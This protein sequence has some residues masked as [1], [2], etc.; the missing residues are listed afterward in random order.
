MDCAME[1]SLNK[2]VVHMYGVYITPVALASHPRWS[3]GLARCSPNGTRV[4]LRLHT[5]VGTQLRTDHR[6]TPRPRKSDELIEAHTPPWYL[7]DPCKTR[8]ISSSMH[9][10]RLQQTRLDWLSS[11]YRAGC[12]EQGCSSGEKSK[13]RFLVISQN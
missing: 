3:V 7:D 10:T 9:V 12:V 13:K 1:Q 8:K 2:T 4:I 5:H 11:T 6:H